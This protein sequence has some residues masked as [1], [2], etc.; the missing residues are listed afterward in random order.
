[1]LFASAGG[2]SA[3]MLGSVREE[4]FDFI[5]NLNA[6]GPLLTAQKALPLLRDGGSIVLNGSIAAIEGFPGLG[7]YA[8]SKAAVRSYARTW[9]AERPLVIVDAR[10]WSNLSR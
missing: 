2:D 3:G 4:D 8:A 1:M 5:F 9:A 6:R 10:L 7:A